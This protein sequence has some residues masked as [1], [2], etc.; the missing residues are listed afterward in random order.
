MDRVVVGEA[1]KIKRLTDN[2]KLSLS[3]TKKDLEIRRSKS[4]YFVDAIE[5]PFGDV[6]RRTIARLVVLWSVVNL[7]AKCIDCTIADSAVALVSCSPRGTP[8]AGRLPSKCAYWWQ[9]MHDD[10]P[11]GTPWLNSIKELPS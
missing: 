3:F 11:G 2:L 10:L 6:L 9:V 8:W 1:K 4:L 5:S 7:G